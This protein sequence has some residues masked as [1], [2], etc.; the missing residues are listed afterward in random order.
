MS[1]GFLLSLGM[2][3]PISS[4]EKRGSAKSLLIIYS[5]PHIHLTTPNNELFTYLRGVLLPIQVSDDISANL[6]GVVVVISE[7]IADSGHSAM[8]VCSSEIFGRH[9]F[10]SSRLHERRTSQENS[11]ISCTYHD[12]KWKTAATTVPYS[13]L[14]PFTITFSSDMAGT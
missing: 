5:I 2:I 8:H 3:P 14:V 7:V 11:T 1:K 12:G 4:A 9:H 13:C 10:A 6:D